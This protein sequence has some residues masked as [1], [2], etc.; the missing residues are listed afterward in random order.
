MQAIFLHSIDEV[1]EPTG[2]KSLI[3]YSKLFSTYKQIIMTK[4]IVQEEDREFKDMI[5]WY[6]AQ[7]F[8]WFNHNDGGDGS[9]SSGIDEVMNQIQDL[10]I[11]TQGD[12][13]DHGAELSA[14]TH[15][16]CYCFFIS[17]TKH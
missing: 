15:V 3:P 17:Y 7:V 5:A 14:D 10:D 8:N 12:D 9:G 11:E 13:K 6:N 16:C 2:R 1:F 4:L